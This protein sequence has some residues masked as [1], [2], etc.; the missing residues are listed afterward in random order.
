MNQALP[1]RPAVQARPEAER[2]SAKIVYRQVP[3]AAVVAY[4]LSTSIKVVVGTSAIG[5]A[6]PGTTGCAEIALLSWKP[7]SYPTPKP[8]RNVEPQTTAMATA[9]RI[10]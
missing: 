3:P 4:A 8:T 6:T 7:E 2:T 9:E 1:R 10:V 5:C